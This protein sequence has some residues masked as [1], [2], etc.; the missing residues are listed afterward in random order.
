MSHAGVK[1]ARKGCNVGN[2]ATTRS[3][4][5]FGG[6]GPAFTRVK[7]EVDV[8]AAKLRRLRALYEGS[9]TSPPEGMRFRVVA[10]LLST[11]EI[12]YL[13]TIGCEIPGVV[14]LPWAEY[15]S[16][17]LELRF[18]SLLNL[19]SEIQT[20][21]R[22][23]PDRLG[24]V[25]DPS[26]ASRMRGTKEWDTL[27]LSG[28][29]YGKVPA[30][31]RL[32][33]KGLTAPAPGS[34]TRTPAGTTRLP[35]AQPPVYSASPPMPAQDWADEVNEEAEL[36][37]AL[38]ISGPKRASPPGNQAATAYSPPQATPGAATYAALSPGWKPAASAHNAPRLGNGLGSATMVAPAS[39]T[40]RPS[41]PPAV[42]LPQSVMPAAVPL[43]STRGPVKSVPA[44]TTVA[45]GG[46]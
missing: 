16:V 10:E 45:G 22:R 19:S 25:I 38:P 9:A 40:A 20:A 43:P 13:I 18:K 26:E 42:P 3:P 46:S 28:S 6:S 14:S 31:A 5:A 8:V 30:A 23:A 35:V 24:R 21:V 34:T 32:A 4:P 41:P 33:M 1:N 12:A 39:S 27:L 15:S 17:D 11:G 37:R 2:N 36:V 7:A 44:P 29:S